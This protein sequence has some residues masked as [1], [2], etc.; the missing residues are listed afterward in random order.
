MNY[1]LESIFVARMLVMQIDWK[2]I[3]QSLVKTY[4]FDSELLICLVT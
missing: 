2:G 4:R 1:Y 3:L